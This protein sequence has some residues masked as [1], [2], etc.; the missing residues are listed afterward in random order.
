MLPPKWCKPLCEN[1]MTFKCV[2]D[3][4]IY[5]DC[6]N[7]KFRDDIKLEDLPDHPLDI[8]LS[9]DEYY[10]LFVLYVCLMQEKI[11]NG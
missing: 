9:K 11:K 8:P 2:K 4:A 10:A 6:S 3:C 1:A 5:R 7:V